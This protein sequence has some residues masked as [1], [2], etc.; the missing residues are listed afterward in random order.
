MKDVTETALEYI[1]LSHPNAKIENKDGERFVHIP[2][3][4]INTDAAWVET[5]RIVKGPDET[6]HGILPVFNVR[7]GPVFN[8]KGDV[9]ETPLGKLFRIV[10]WTPPPKDK[11]GQD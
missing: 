6:K 7:S 2:C 1:L 10:G 9:H 8:P 5:R 4:D 11:D 3:Y